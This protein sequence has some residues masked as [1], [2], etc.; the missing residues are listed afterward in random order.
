M[1]ST[2]RLVGFREADRLSAPLARAEAQLNGRGGPIRALAISADSASALS[3]N[4][5]TAAI[6]WSLRRNAA[7]PVLRLHESAVNAVAILKDARAITPG[8][9]DRI[10]IWTPGKTGGRAP[11]LKGHKGPIVALTALPDNATLADYAVVYGRSRRTA[12]VGRLPAERQRRCFRA[13]R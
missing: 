5:D 9:N 3:G 2:A 4:F 7:G 12:R 11:A 8:E 13:R 6:R 10:A 1:R